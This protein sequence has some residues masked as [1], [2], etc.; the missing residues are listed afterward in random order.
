MAASAQYR[1]GSVRW[2]M[3]SRSTL[4]PLPFGSSFKLSMRC[5]LYWVCIVFLFVC[6]GVN[7]FSVSKE[8]LKHL[9]RIKRERTFLGGNEAFPLCLLWTYNVSMSIFLTSSRFAYYFTFLALRVDTQ[10]LFEG[11]KEG[12]KKFSKWV[13]VY[14][15]NPAIYLNRLPKLVPLSNPSI[16]SSTSLLTFAAFCLCVHMIIIF[17]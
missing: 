4:L 8:R 11:G 17:P 15:L 1:D 9:L 10:K 3:G 7:Y 5:H 2:D 13:R 16:S 14:I 12:N 6:F